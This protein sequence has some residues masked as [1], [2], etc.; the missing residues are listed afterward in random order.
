[1]S[2]TGFAIL[3]I[4]PF[5][6]RE[7]TMSR[8]VPILLIVG[9]VMGLAPGDAPARDVK[10]RMN[11]AQGSPT[12]T[13]TV[14]D[15]RQPFESAITGMEKIEGLFTFYWD[16]DSGKTFMEIKP[17]QLGHIYLC[18][19]TREAGDGQYYDSSAQVREF[20]FVFVKAGHSIQFVHK[21]VYFRADEGKPISRALNRG[22]SDSIVGTASMVSKPSM[23]G[24]G[25]LVS[26]SDFFLQD[27][28]FVGYN[29]GRASRQSGFS[30]DKSNSRFFEIKSFPENSEIETEV[31]FQ[32]RT[33]SRTSA[34]PEPTSMLHRYHFSLSSL[35]ETGY[36]PRLADDRVGF[37]TT[38]YQDYNDV[39]RESAY[40]R[41]INRWH[42]EKENPLAELSPPKEPIVF[43][44]EN[45][46]PEKYRP[47]VKDGIEKWNKAFEKAGFKD[48]I[49][50]KQMPD[51]AEWDPADSRYNTIRWMVQPGG[52]YAV[53]P[54]RTNPFTGQ[55]YDADIRISADML[56]YVYMSHVEYVDP[57]SILREFPALMD[58]FKSIGVLDRPGSPL[59]SFEDGGGAGD[60]YGPGSSGCA[61][62]HRGCDYQAGKSREAAFGLGLLM[63][64][65][66]TDGTDQRAENYVKDYIAE[67]VCHEV[68]HTLGL[69]HNF[70]A[71][72]IRTLEEL[73]DVRLTS[74][75]GLMGS[76][77]EYNP[78]NLARRGEEQGE[79]FHS[80]VGPYDMWAIEYGYI[81]IDVETTEEELP[82]LNEIA[83][84]V[85]E[86]D[87]IYGTDEDS[88]GFDPRG[89][90]P[91]CNLWDLGADPLR[92]YERQVDLASELWEKVELEFEQPGVRYQ[93]LRNV[94]NRGVFQYIYAGINCSK[95]IGG[96]YARR[97]HIGDPGNRL[98]M[99]PV[100]A[101]KQRAALDFIIENHLAAD[102][103]DFDAELLNKLAPERFWDFEGSIFRQVR[104]D[105]AVHNAVFAMQVAPLSRLYHPIVLAR[106]QDLELR[107][108]P[109]QQAFTMEEM[110]TS[111][112]DAVWSE[113]AGP[114][115]I[116]SFR[117]ELQ[118]VHLAIL[119]SHVVSMG[120]GVP[121]DASTL[122]R[123]DLNRILRGVDRALAGG[124]IDSMTRVH[125]DEV[126]A[127]IEA[128]LDAGIDRRAG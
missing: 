63:A 6:L 117:R 15:P 82:H 54:S 99:E 68:G 109:G 5:V 32:R 87:L 18:S 23:V 38:M 3:H 41:Y 10:S 112:R 74:E 98:P 118:R 125:L 37:F 93:K 19:I 58:P 16:E 39:E 79:Y 26:P 75:E 56:R 84:R 27:V 42:L 107:Y 9:L 85:S 8:F 29:T 110:Y 103:F 53:G 67:T 14:P 1:L 25:Y 126:K 83:S 88:F 104:L 77:M 55:I 20:P 108:E 62:S 24:G 127:R 72:T 33:P 114:R 124:G 121:Q 81:P 22:L 12:R 61:D 101:A 69:R 102:A 80:S 47:A 46:V 128:A 13:E 35:P 78:V 57:L 95:Y 65:G 60:C 123:A 105:Y 89:I 11:R 51:D 113:L 71:S 59:G 115:P 48:A 50:A 120:A 17:D 106:L 40:V 52:G 21:N 122:A 90:D 28:G 116:N 31:H 30:F 92:Y 91:A 94:F 4:E 44:I 100:P 66:L 36:R 34:L 76:V 49:V 64:R 86:P 111:V 119:M 43:W 97:D 2:D 73:N 45:T 96:I 7:E 70:K